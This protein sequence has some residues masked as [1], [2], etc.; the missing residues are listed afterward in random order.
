VPVRLDDPRGGPRSGGDGDGS[1]PQRN[2]RG[3]RAP[4]GRGGPQQPQEPWHPGAARYAR[5]PRRDQPSLRGPAP[6]ATEYDY[7]APQYDNREYD[8]REYEPQPRGTGPQETRPQGALRDRPEVSREPRPSRAPSRAGKSKADKTKGSKTKAKIGKIKAGK[9]RGLDSAEEQGTLAAK[10][11]AGPIKAREQVV[12]TRSGRRTGRRRINVVP[13]VAVTSAVVV[14]ITVGT[15]AY[16]KIGPGAPNGSGAAAAFNALTN[17][18]ALGAL[19]AERE[20]IVAMNAATQVMTTT[21]KPLTASV[22]QATSDSADEAANDVGVVDAATPA[23]AQEIA[24]ELM[25]SY[26]FSVADQFSCLY[27]IWERESGWEWDAENTASAAYGIPQSLPASKMA[28][29]GSDYLT[30]ATTQI[31]WGLWYIQNRYGTPCAAWDFELD[32]GFY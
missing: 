14:L 26:G 30:D 17:S 21:S 19:E 20:Q 32:N 23:E 9:V 28:M 13:A 15:A 31:K 8:D 12:D 24:Q 16:Y 22:S 7:E 18:K 10:T 6:R 1:G 25:P 5:D 11:A 3:N 4:D 29:F 27:D 2:N